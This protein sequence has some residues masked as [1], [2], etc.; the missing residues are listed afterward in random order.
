MSGVQSEIAAI[1]GKGLPIALKTNIFIQFLLACKYSQ[2]ACCIFRTVHY[3]I[4][5]I[6][7]LNIEALKM[8]QYW[9]LVGSASDSAPKTTVSFLLSPWSCVIQSDWDAVI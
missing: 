9:V 1:F 3:K 5:S 8:A 4:W 6:C 7:D 2:L